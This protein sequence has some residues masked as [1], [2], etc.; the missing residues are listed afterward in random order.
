MKEIKE[1]LL[2]TI[3]SKVS[4]FEKFIVIKASVSTLKLITSI[5]DP[6]NDFEQSKNIFS[7]IHVL[8]KTGNGFVLQDSTGTHCRI[9]ILASPHTFHYSILSGAVGNTFFACAQPKTARF[10]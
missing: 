5:E 1:F 6:F 2:L 3:P 7:F 4:S 9:I 8:E 10:V